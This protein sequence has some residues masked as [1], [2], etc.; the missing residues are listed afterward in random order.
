MRTTRV[1]RIHATSLLCILAASTLGCS[2]GEGFHC[3]ESG[4]WTTTGSLAQRRA[5]F[6]ME[7]LPSGKVLAAAGQAI[8]GGDDTVTATAEIYDPDTGRWSSAA[9]MATARTL[10][11]SAVV[12]GGEVLVAGG[13]GLAGNLDTAEVYDPATDTWAATAGPMSVRRGLPTCTLLDSGEVLVAGGLGDAASATADLYD[14]AT[15]HFTATGSMATARY[16]HTATRLADGRVLVA[17]GC[18]GGWPCESST[19]STEIYDP[20][21]GLW[22]AADSLPSPVVSHV[23]VRL[24]SGDVFVAGGCTTYAG[25][26]RCGN[27]PRDRTASLYDPDPAPGTWAAEPSM[28]VGHADHAAMLLDSGEVMLV[29]G[30]YFSGSGTLTERFDPSTSAWGCG[31]STGMEHGNGVRAVRLQD[32]RWLAAGGDLQTVPNA[33]DYTGATEIFEE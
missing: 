15:G 14:P 18:T 16:W 13:S 5:F 10:P 17:G 4:S 3:Q 21:T 28:K 26:G 1:G 25:S 30:G 11:C 6:A 19:G 12:P 22:N 8:L 2:S 29:G 20:D 7:V 9:S 31:P 27:S 23:A 32:G 24:G 33:N